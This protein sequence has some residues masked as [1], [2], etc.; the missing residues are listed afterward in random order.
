[1]IDLIYLFISLVV[2][3]SFFIAYLFYLLRQ[4]K[5]KPRPDSVELTEFLLDLRAGGAMLHC[6]R[7]DPSDIVMRSP[8]R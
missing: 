6:R 3:Q 1:M 5:K 7:L 2:I 4:E 8:R